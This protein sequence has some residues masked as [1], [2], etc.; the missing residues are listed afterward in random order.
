M[1]ALFAVIFINRQAVYLLAV[2]L[3]VELLFFIAADGFT[4]SLFMAAAYSCA[5]TV[6]IRL[7]SEIR[8]VLLLVG[9]LNWLAAVDYLIAPNYETY[10]FIC[11]PYLINGLDVLVLYYL[12]PKGAIKNAG[13]F[14]GS[15]FR[16]LA[17]L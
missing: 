4:A 12:L 2:E 13:R 16:A 14:V 8:H 6:N 9:C 10:F 7:K 3:A 15:G 17:N 1:A 5:S 11:Y